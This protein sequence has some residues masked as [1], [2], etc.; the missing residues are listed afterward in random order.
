MTIWYNSTA[1]IIDDSYYSIAYSDGWSLGGT[2]QEYQQTTHGSKCSAGGCNFT[3]P[4]L[5]TAIEV[6]GTTSAGQNPVAQFQIDALPVSV[7]EQGAV[8][9]TTYGNIFY[10]S[11][12]LDAGQ[13][14]LT[15]T[16][17]NADTLWRPLGSVF[18][19][20]LVFVVS[21]ACAVAITCIV[22]V[23]FLAACAI[24]ISATSAGPGPVFTS[25]VL[26]RITIPIIIA[27]IFVALSHPFTLLSVD[28]SFNT[29]RTPISYRTRAYTLGFTDFYPTNNRRRGF[30]K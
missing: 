19:S 15:V 17:T 25:T 23:T 2:P 7:Y 9:D 18:L 14:T 8:S 11:P 24:S 10:S 30:I 4:F 27:S 20:F 16:V 12:T 26:C 3:F 13:H 22:S 1:I 28:L 21:A 29:L 5:G 6:L